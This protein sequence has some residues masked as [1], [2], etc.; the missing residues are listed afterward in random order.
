MA[1]MGGVELFA[2]KMPPKPA[3]SN[4][5]QPLTK[6]PVGPTVKYGVIGLTRCD[7]AGRFLKSLALLPN[8]PVT[9]ICDKHRARSDGPVTFAPEGGTVPKITKYFWPARKSRP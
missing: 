1:M 9:A 2:L 5:P 6:I 4:A 7:G 8:A 3:A